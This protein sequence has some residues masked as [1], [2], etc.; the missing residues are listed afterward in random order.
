MSSATSVARRPPS[1]ETVRVERR[2]AAE[3]WARTTPTIEPNSALSCSCHLADASTDR[4]TSSKRL[5]STPSS[6]SSL[7][8]KCQY[9][10]MGVTPSLLP[11]PRIVTAS[12]PS[13]S[14][15][16][17]AASTTVR[18]VRA[19]LFVAVWRLFRAIDDDLVRSCFATAPDDVFT[20]VHRTG[21]GFSL[22][23][24]HE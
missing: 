5:A 6:S 20:T 14:A 18:R 19:T 17:S 21:Y 24:V 7:L 2:V 1:E 16:A 11:N 23:S 9:T 13:A 8:R 22:Y 3:G 12:S 10:A 4:S 15:S